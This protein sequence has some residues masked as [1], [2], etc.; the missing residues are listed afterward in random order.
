MAEAH[1]GC[2]ACC[3]LFHHG[4][5]QRHLRILD[6]NTLSSAQIR[7]GQFLLKVSSAQTL[8]FVCEVHQTH[9]G[10]KFD[11]LAWL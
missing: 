8:V 3:C 7:V 6:L 4:E 9:A 5:F 11:G 10:V 2:H 1:R